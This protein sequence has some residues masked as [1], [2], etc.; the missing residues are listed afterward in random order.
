M[1]YLARSLYC[2]SS[3]RTHF[4]GASP[5]LT[6]SVTPFQSRTQW[7]NPIP[8][9]ALLAAA[10]STNIAAVL[11]TSLVR[12]LGFVAVLHVNTIVKIY[13]LLL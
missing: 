1:G 11:V 13:Y 3:V 9:F 10:D 8:P 12:V 4:S 6:I 5:M 2:A 7:G